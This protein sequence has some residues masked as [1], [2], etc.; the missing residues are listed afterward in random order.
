[1]EATFAKLLFQKN[2]LKMIPNTP[3]KT[4]KYVHFAY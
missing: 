4:D 1:M 2:R 3:I